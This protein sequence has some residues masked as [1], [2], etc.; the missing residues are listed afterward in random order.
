[1]PGQK[2]GAS[3]T[4]SSKS[5]APNF[6][7]G[8]IFKRRDPSPGCHVERSETSLII[9]GELGTMPEILRFAQDD[10]DCLSDARS[11]L[12]SQRQFHSVVGDPHFHT[13]LGGDAA[14]LRRD[15]AFVAIDNFRTT[16]TDDCARHAL[17]LTPR[18][19]GA[20][21]RMTD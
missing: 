13:A 9:A 15:F 2:K 11:N 6:K 18:Q 8:P 5:R 14:E 12:V 20:N 10:N 21:R 19:L 17:F 1:M 16:M 3:F 7:E 4:L